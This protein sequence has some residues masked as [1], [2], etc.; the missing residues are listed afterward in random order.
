MSICLMRTANWYNPMTA[1]NQETGV[2][3]ELKSIVFYNNSNPELLKINGGWFTYPANNSIFEDM[4][5]DGS[6]RRKVKN[7][8]ENYVYQDTLYI[9][10]DYAELEIGPEKVAKEE[11]CG[12]YYEKEVSFVIAGHII[13]THTCPWRYEEK[14]I[15]AKMKAIREKIKDKIWVDVY[16]EKIPELYK[17]LK[18]EM[19]DED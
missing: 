15:A 19:E 7:W 4:V 10:A 13:K 1:L 16:E 6:F 17:L 8:Q 11:I 12:T 9:Y 2:A 14:P 18:E 3:H 5:I